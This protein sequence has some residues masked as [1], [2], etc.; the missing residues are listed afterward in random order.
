MGAKKEVKIGNIKIGGSNPVAVQSM[1]NIVSDNT[2]GCVAQAKELE[3]AGC[4]I[5][6]ATVPDMKA[7]HT[8]AK[9]KENGEYKLEKSELEKIKSEF[10][11][12][13]TS[14][15]ETIKTIKDVYEKHGYPF[16]RGLTK[17]E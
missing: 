14:E 13:F 4:E 15:E 3:K 6:R 10:E 17:S 12:G 2:D 9:L 11:A 7:V 5:I 8:M 16:R 1:L